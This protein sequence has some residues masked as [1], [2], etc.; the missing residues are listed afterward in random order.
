[1][2]KEGKEKK[3]GDKET[4]KREECMRVSEPWHSPGSNPLIGKQGLVFICVWIVIFDKIAAIF[5]SYPGLN[6]SV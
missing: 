3:V 6:E 5:C 2:T 1:M 4:K